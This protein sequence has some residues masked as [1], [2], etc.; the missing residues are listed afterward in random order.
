VQ[1]GDKEMK[2]SEQERLKEVWRQ[3]ELAAGRN[4]DRGPICSRVLMIGAF[5]LGALIWYFSK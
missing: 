2:N 1:K 3:Q 4:P 5:L